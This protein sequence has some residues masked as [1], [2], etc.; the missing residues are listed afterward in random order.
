LRLTDVS[1]RKVYPAFLKLLKSFIVFNS[2]MHPL[3]KSAVLL[4]LFLA[5]QQA[6]A[7]HYFEVRGASSK[8]RYFDSNYTF[9]NSLLV[10]MFYVGVP[11]GNEFNVGGGYGFK[12]IPSLMIAPMAYAVI[13]KEA[14]QR[15]VKGALLVMFEKD[16]WKANSFLG[17]IARLAGR[18]EIT[19][20]SIRWISAALHTA[21]LKSASLA[22][23]FTRV[24]N[25][26]RK[27]ARFS[28]STTA[29]D[30]GTHQCASDHKM[31]YVLHGLSFLESRRSGRFFKRTT[32]ACLRARL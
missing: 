11:G 17:Q 13:G 4:A 27:T 12:P 1:F 28:G 19:R 8:Y 29:S 20:F 3:T 30:L 18:S 22:D 9:S 23:S 25:G 26:T 14:G 32:S 31:N 7:Q 15:G 5:G 24:E 16:G 21:R 2:F 10:D 6:L